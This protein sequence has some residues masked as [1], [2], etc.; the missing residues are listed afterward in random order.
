[1]ASEKQPRGVYHVTSDPLHA[2]HVNV[3]RQTLEE[4]G[5]VDGVEVVITNDHPEKAVLTKFED[6]VALADLTIFEFFGADDRVHINTIEAE[7]PTP[8]LT[9]ATLERLMSEFDAIL[10]ILGADNFPEI[11][12]WENIGPVL[13]QTGAVVVRRSKDEELDI[14]QSQPNVVYL[15]SGIVIPIRSVTARSTT[16]YYGLVGMVGQLA[17][18]YIRTNEL[19]GF[20]A[21]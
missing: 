8:S 11:Y 4:E 10:P 5:L 20:A 17:A 7:L 16:N 18:E 15:D 1:M 21:Q 6:R 14:P 19:Y 13:E 2:G 3:I 9:H 12:S